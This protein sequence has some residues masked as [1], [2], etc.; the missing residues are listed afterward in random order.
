[1]DEFVGEESKSFPL[2]E[3]RTPVPSNID[4]AHHLT[5]LRESHAQRSSFV[6]RK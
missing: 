1:L 4:L 3:P 6:F 5:K 2:L